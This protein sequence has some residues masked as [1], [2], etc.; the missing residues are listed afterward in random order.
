MH[1]DF[2][3]IEL[4]TAL[5]PPYY[6]VIFTSLRPLGTDDGYGPAAE[7]MSGMAANQPGYLGA[8]SWRN[9][10][11]L[12]VTLSYRA[13]EA[14]LR[15]WKRNQEHLAAQQQGRNHWYRAYRVEVA[16]VERA[17]GHLGA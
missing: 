3:P 5:E 11:G 13:D 2:A 8:H 15:A 9:A 17:Y 14:A 6:V 7:Y 12:G 10:Q 16:R 1:P 4:L